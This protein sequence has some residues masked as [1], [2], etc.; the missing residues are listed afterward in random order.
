MKKGIGKAPLKYISREKSDYSTGPYRNDFMRDRDRILY[1]KPFRR[2]SRKTQI[3]LPASDDHVR[4][5]LTHSLE[6]AQISKVSAQALGLDRDLTEAIALGHDI[7]HTPFGHTGERV[8]NLIATNCDRLGGLAPDINIKQMGF[9]HNLQGI[10]VTADLDLLYHSASGLNLSNYTLW[11]ICN[12]TSK[13]WK[14]CG[15]RQEIEEEKYI[16]NNPQNRKIASCIHGN[17]KEAL[18]NLFYDQYDQLLRIKNDNEQGHYAWSFEGFLVERADEIAQR[19]HD[20]EDGLIANVILTSDILEWVEEL[21]KPYF[22]KEENRIFS[23][24]NKSNSD[25]EYVIP[26]IS[27]IIVGCLNRNLITNSASN[28][29]S[30]YKAFSIQSKSDFME[31]YPDLDT[32]TVF[33]ANIGKIQIKDIISYPP[34]LNIDEGILKKKLKNGILNSYQVQRM[35]GKAKFLIRQLSKAYL[36]NPQQLP[37]NMIKHLFLYCY[38]D[39]ENIPHL[40]NNDRRSWLNEMYYSSRNNEVRKNLLRV[41]CDYISSMTDDFAIT[42]HA[43]LYSTSEIG[44]RY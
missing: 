11:G 18:K 39:K 37:D 33:D 21:I 6:V 1:S 9:K 26:K 23:S 16:C 20:I 8:L 15:Y 38:P 7:G 35:D 5:R 22:S 36:S 32:D 43:R 31:I 10:R 24:L 34:H 17:N 25:S 3:F 14:K 4:T 41:I 30:F 40:T 28:L 19:H 13:Y 2:L 42:E 29:R 27:K 44:A 12:H